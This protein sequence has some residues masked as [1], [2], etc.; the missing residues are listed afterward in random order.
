[1][2]AE[3]EL[4]TAPGKGE[5]IFALRA[6][7]EGE[8]VLIGVLEESDVANHSHASQLG[9]HEFGYH[10]GLTS[11]FNH[12]CDPNCGIRLNKS[13]A[14]DF[15]AMRRI[16]SH[17]E[18]TFDYAMRNYRIEHF[19]DACICGSQDCRG[20]V[21]GWQTLPQ[22]RKDEYAGFVAPYLVEMDC[23]LAVAVA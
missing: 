4:R 21:T 19:P 8:T 16:D 20:A 5:G 1:M 7:E 6:F 11:K 3:I 2:T 12:S 23:R 17:E 13:G 10:S 14:H 9:E 15:V 18:T 22:S